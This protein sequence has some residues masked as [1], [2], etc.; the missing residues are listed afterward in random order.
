[1]NLEVIGFNETV[2]LDRVPEERRPALDRGGGRSDGPDHRRR[3]D[4]S[5][6]PERRISITDFFDAE[7]IFID[8]DISSAEIIGLMLPVSTLRG[9]QKARVYGSDNH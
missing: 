9:S 4:G 3:V 7:M 1:M 2:R 8:P 6:D 5:I